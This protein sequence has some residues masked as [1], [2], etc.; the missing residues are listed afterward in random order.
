MLSPAG[1]AN[2]AAVVA[3]GLASPGAYADG[4][5]VLTIRGRLLADTVTRMLTE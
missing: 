1:Q 4:R 2:A 5:I 3:E